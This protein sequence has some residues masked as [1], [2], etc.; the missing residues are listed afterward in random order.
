MHRSVYSLVPAAVCVCTCV[1]SCS[2]MERVLYRYSEVVELHRTVQDE[3]IL[4]SALA[5]PF[6]DGFCCMLLL[7]PVKLLHVST[8]WISYCV[9]L[10]VCMMLLL[11]AAFSAPAVVA[12]YFC[13]LF[14]LV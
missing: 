3:D 8:C 14:L 6:R 11:A 13:S 10:V 4:S 1:A 12:P 7:L 2:Y 9:F 5:L